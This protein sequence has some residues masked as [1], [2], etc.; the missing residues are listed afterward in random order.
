MRIGLRYVRGLSDALLDRIDAARVAGGPFTDLESFT[1]RTGAPVDALEALAT[2][3]A[4]RSLG[5]ERREAL[6]AAGAL[7]D[8]RPG[9]LPGVVTGIGAPP[10]PGMDPID[11]TN[12]DLWATGMSPGRHPTEFV[13]GALAARGAVT[14]EALRS[15][16]DL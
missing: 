14:A 8:A 5:V 10:L 9:T 13:R 16:P 4:F 3:G 11:E 15:L 2:A 6:W 1:R 12:A 7:R